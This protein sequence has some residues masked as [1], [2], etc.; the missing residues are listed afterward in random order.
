MRCGDDADDGENVTKEL[1]LAYYSIMGRA[2]LWLLGFIFFVCCFD[3]WWWDVKEY[4]IHSV[5]YIAWTLTG[6]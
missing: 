5:S 6:S 4:Y 3:F 1:L 2:F